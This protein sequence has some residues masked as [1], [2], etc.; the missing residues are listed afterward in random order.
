MSEP[1]SQAILDSEGHKKDLRYLS[2]QDSRAPRVDQWS[3]GTMRRPS[4]AG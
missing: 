2:N 1:R 3:N 4:C